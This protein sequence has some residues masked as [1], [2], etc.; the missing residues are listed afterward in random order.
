MTDGTGTT[1]WSYGPVGALGALRLA[2]ETGPD[3]A[4]ATV[5]YGY[6]AL[7]R[8]TSRTVAGAS[9][10]IGY[11]VLGRV[12]SLTNPLGSFAETWLGDTGQPFSE[13]LLGGAAGTTWSWL[14][15]QSDRRLAA[16]TYSG[17]QGNEA[18]STD[19]EGRVLARLDGDGRVRQYAYDGADQVLSA[20]DSDTTG[21]DWTSLDW[22]HYGQTDSASIGVQLAQEQ[23]AY[24]AAGNRVSLTTSG[25]ATPWTATGRIFAYDAEDRLVSVT[26]TPATPPPS[27]M[28]A[29]A[30]EQQPSSRPPTALQSRPA[31][32]G[33][34]TPRAP[35]AL[36]MAPS[37]PDTSNKAKSAPMEA[38]I[39]TVATISAA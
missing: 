21:F 33:V 37:P 25:D 18:L 32:F 16:L 5:S 28:T 15:N 29:S 2:A 10:T 35:P 38:R 13:T 19:A 17:G 9:E 20:T 36:P 34:P 11:D 27:A 14:G 24:D 8:V 3:G 6:D 30:A 12:A 23:Y 22:S 26:P 31:P 7:G 39:I 4:A 1:G